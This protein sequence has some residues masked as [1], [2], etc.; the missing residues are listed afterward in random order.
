M[1]RSVGDNSLH[2]GRSLF[3]L[4]AM[5]LLPADRCYPIE[6]PIDISLGRALRHRLFVAIVVPLGGEGVACPV[7]SVR[8]IE[9]LPISYVSAVLQQLGAG[10][11]S[12]LFDLPSG[13]QQ[14]FSQLAAAAPLPP[15]SPWR[16]WLNEG[17]YLCFQ[18]QSLAIAQWLDLLLGGHQPDHS[19]PP[20]L[21]PT[22]DSPVVWEYI[23]T[24]CTQLQ[25]LVALPERVPWSIDGKLFGGSVPE[26]QLVAALVDLWDVSV[27]RGWPGQN[28]PGLGIGQKTIDKFLAFEQ[29]CQLGRPTDRQLAM[30]QVGLVRAM[31]ISAG[32]VLQRCWGIL[33]QLHW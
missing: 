5:P 16:G 1:R 17:G 2:P 26:N 25:Q 18:P 7:I 8:R 28:R 29:T 6:I 20:D 31:Q 11:E 27:D 24:R 23:Y 13:G 10:R 30:A 32:M 22:A 19:P 9:S 3:L 33:P 4:L 15:L 12:D 14:L 21:V